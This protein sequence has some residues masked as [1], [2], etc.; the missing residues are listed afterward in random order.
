MTPAVHRLRD[1]FSLPG[2][3]ILQWAFFDPDGR[4]NDLP[5]RH[6]L[7]AVV[8]PGTHDNDTVTGWHRSTSSAA[9]ERFHSYAGEDAR[10]DPA[11]AMTRLAF[12]S[13]ANTAIVQMQ[14]LLGLGRRARMNVP[15]KPTG[16]WCWRLRRSD[17]GTSTA[18][19]LS[20]LAT[21]TG[22]GRSKTNR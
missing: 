7:H 12:T 1:D 10:E 19:R 16:N 9:K 11:A 22:C 13:P 14:D 3:R 5:H 8:Y 2:M 18:R 21:S 17:L 4:S 15:G 6:P 20:R